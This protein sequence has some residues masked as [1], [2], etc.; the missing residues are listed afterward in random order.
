MQ[1]QY[2]ATITSQGQMT[3]PVA[4]RRALNLDTKKK[5]TVNIRLQAN[6]ML[7]EPVVDFLE[8]AGSLQEYAMQGKT[9][10]EILD[11]EKKVVEKARIEDYKESLKRMF[12]EPQ[13]Y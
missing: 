11:I 10:E 9:P 1:T 13:I 4:I 6:T 5:Q 12:D 2:T 7:V 8:L 3:V